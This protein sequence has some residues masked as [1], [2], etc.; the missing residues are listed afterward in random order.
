MV[1]GSPF[2]SS[3]ELGFGS[4]LGKL[5][6]R[7]WSCC[8]MAWAHL[9]VHILLWEI[10]ACPPVI[11]FLVGLVFT[12][13]LVRSVRSRLYVRREAL[14][15][16]AL[17]AQIGEKCRLVDTLRAAAEKCAGIQSSLAGARQERE[18][19]N[20]PS[21]ADACREATTTYWMLKQEMTSLVQE[22]EEERSKCSRQE[23]EM[24]QMLRTLESLEEVVKISTSQA[25][26]ASLPGCQETS[27]AGLLLRSGPGS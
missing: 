16:K 8:P 25:A 13:R 7:Q 2:V 19:L 20:I 1:T 17:A 27:P 10:L 5:A 18:S 6:R 15:A 12:V 14:L 24:V 26:V 23:E 21:L 11:G 22:L 4:I 9:P 3:V